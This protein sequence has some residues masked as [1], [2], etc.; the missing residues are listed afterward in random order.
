[1]E[2]RNIVGVAVTAI[3]HKY[4]V[5][6]L[7]KA[8][9]AMYER[10]ETVF[11]PIRFTALQESARCATSTPGIQLHLAGTILDDLQVSTICVRLWMRNHP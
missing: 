7:L 5:W 2:L 1:M 6:S 9:A 4:F 11:L 3:L 10:C 8:M